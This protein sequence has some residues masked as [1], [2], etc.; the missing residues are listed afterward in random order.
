MKPLLVI[1]KALRPSSLIPLTHKYTP[2]TFQAFGCWRANRP[3]ELIWL[4]SGRAECAKRELERL[5]SHSTVGKILEHHLTEHIRL[6]AL[7]E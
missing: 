1:H 5:A 7:L 4:E 6:A 2:W 3:G